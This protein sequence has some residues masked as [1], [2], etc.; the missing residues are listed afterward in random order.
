MFPETKSIV[1]D[2]ETTQLRADI[3]KPVTW[4]RGCREG[5]GGERRKET[6]GGRTHLAAHA[7]VAGVL[8]AATTWPTGTT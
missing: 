2:E 3:N 4:V 1:E 8:L 7:L 6:D 5:L